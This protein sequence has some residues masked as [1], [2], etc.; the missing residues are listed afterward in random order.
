MFGVIQLLWENGAVKIQEQPCPVRLRPASAR[1]R[2]CWEGAPK[3]APFHLPD[4]FPYCSAINQ[5]KALFLCFK[6]PSVCP[7]PPSPGVMQFLLAGQW[8]VTALGTLQVKLK[9]RVAFFF[10]FMLLSGCNTN[11]RDSRCLS[12]PI[13]QGAPRWP[14]GASCYRKGLFCRST[15]KLLPER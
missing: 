13:V 15:C 12:I 3:T 5:S 1:S 8:V 7:R 9:S 6:L 2:Q 4:T 11:T 10:F 14:G